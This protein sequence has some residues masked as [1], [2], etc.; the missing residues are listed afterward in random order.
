LKAPDPP[1]A[2][3]RRGASR[4]LES[5]LRQGRSLDD[6]LD[7]ALRGITRP[8]DRALARSLASG[9]LRWLPDLDTLID[10]AM[11]KPLPDDARARQALRIGMVG[12]LLLGTPDHAVIATTLAL[13]EGGPRRL[14][15]A[16]LSRLLRE[17][18]VLPDA[19]TLP[20]PFAG[21]WA[22]SA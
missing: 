3:A 5:V 21:R 8:D 20:P 19:P 12:H 11:A 1:G 9:V 18:A 7:S 16:V 10:G 22:A 4:L 6:A 17:G 14:A 2:A 15:H 13:L